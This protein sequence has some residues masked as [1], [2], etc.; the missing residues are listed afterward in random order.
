MGLLVLSRK[1][2]QE[3][4][5]GDNIVI[6]VVRIDRD[7]VRIGIQAPKDVIVDRR[8]IRDMKATRKETNQADE[9]GE[10]KS[11]DTEPTPG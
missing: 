6:T 8:E 10:K 3:I 5:I 9:K 1:V 11:L 2:G 7:K 4:T